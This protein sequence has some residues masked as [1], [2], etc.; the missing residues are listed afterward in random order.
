MEDTKKTKEPKRLAEMQ[1]EIIAILN[2]LVASM[3]MNTSLLQENTQ[4]KE[5][6]IRLELQTQDTIQVPPLRNGI[7]KIVEEPVK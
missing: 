5:K 6:V 4:L 3:E 2:K 7:L 1:E